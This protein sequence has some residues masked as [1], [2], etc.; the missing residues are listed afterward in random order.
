MSSMA[1]GMTPTVTDGSGGGLIAFLG[2]TIEKNELVDAT[3]SALRTGCLKV[4]SVEDNWEALDLRATDLDNIINRFK[5]KHRMDMKD[6]TREQY[7]QR[8]R[9]S[10]E[11]YLKWLDDDPTWKPAQRKKAVPSN[12]GNGGSKKVTPQAA[13]A[14]PQ[15]EVPIKQ[16]P[17]QAGMISY[18]FPIRPGLRGRIEL[19]EDLTAREAKR[20]AA[21]ISTL[22]VEEELEPVAP[23]AIEGRRQQSESWAASDE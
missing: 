11:M 6:R 19:P 16:D 2:W 4:L 9:Q 12:G 15:P 14:S 23:L 18:P 1:E 20:I 10:V 5:N 22:A 7:E 8:F 17:P 21:F 13:P 3:A